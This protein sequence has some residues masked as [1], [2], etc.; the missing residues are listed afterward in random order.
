MNCGINGHPRTTGRLVCEI[1]KQ[2]FEQPGT[3]EAFAEW[4]K[5]YDP[6]KYGPRAVKNNGG[7]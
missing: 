7:N 4:L 3:A 6:N 2:Y 1:T 5:S